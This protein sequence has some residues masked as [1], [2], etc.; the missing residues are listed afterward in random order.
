MGLPLPCSLTPTKVTAFKDCAY[1]FRL[2][3]IDKVPQPLSIWTVKGVLAHRALERFYFTIP[4]LERTPHKARIIVQ[5]EL[6]YGLNQGYA[7]SFLANLSEAA[8]VR[9]AE[10]VEQLVMNV[11]SLE[12][13][14][15]TNVLG[16]ELMLEFQ[17]GDVLARGVIDR[18]DRDP[19]GELVVVD[20]KTGR[21]PSHTHEQD[22]LAGVLFY[23]LLVERVL[24][25]RPKS[26]KLMY[27]RD[28]MVIESEATSHRL[29]AVEGKTAAIWAAVRMACETGNFRPRP[30]RLCNFCAYQCQCPSFT[31]S[32]RTHTLQTRRTPPA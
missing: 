27:L 10:E 18:L 1:A 8:R 25:V 17:V 26:V 32:D 20:Y 29:Q 6:N 11:F 31:S 15:T 14:T 19:D 28:R 24:G 22:K 23:A 4:A 5:D 21:P 16:T 12:D 9:L 13:P 7:A 3:V 2:S 30:S